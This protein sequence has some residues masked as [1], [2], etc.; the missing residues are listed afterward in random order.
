MEAGRYAG[1]I[2][3]RVQRSTEFLL[4]NDSYSNKRHWAPPKGKVIGNEDQV[5]CAIRETVDITGL[6]AKS[7]QIADSNFRI[8]IKYLSGTTPKHVA[9]FVASIAS[10]ER[11]VPSGLAGLNMAW[12][13]LQQAIEKCMYKNM[14]DALRQANAYIEELKTKIPPPLSTN[15][16]SGFG[17]VH[18]EKGNVNGGVPSENGRNRGDRGDRRKGGGRGSHKGGEEGGAYSDE[19]AGGRMR[20]GEGPGRPGTGHSQQVPSAR[21]GGSRS[22]SIGED[23]TIARVGGSVFDKANGNEK[24]LVFAPNGSKVHWR[25]GGVIPGSTMPAST[26]LTSKEKKEETPAVPTS[27][28][29]NPLYKTRLCERFETE[30]NCPYGARCSFAHGTSELRDRSTYIGD[31]KEQKNEQADNPLYKTRYCERFLKE[32][33]CQYGPRCNFAHSPEELRVRPAND[34]AEQAKQD[35]ADAAAAQNAHPPPVKVTKANRDDLIT[36]KDLMS[37]K[38]KVGR[39]NTRVVE[40]PIGELQPD[41]ANS[42][43]GASPLSVPAILAAPL[44]ATGSVSSPS[45]PSATVVK[46]NKIEESLVGDLTKYFGSEA[47]RTIAEETKEITRIEFKHDL[48]KQQ[49]FNVLIPSLF[50]EDYTNGKLQERKAFLQQYIRTSSDQTAFLKAWDKAMNRNA[51]LMKK[52]TVVFKCLYDVDLIEEDIFMAW[53]QGAGVSEAVKKKCQ[54]L[55]EWFKTAEEEED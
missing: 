33:F 32:S 6:S 46:L 37:D 20:R 12:L 8:E 24:N 27:V 26:L 25:T 16:R 49:L 50:D 28:T 45:T 40:V 22:L 18:N 14:Q 52:A 3:Y 31:Q 38:D 7:I 51:N 42:S 53:S 2:L 44:S 13:P 34:E 5:K 21:A 29:E 30:G 41:R 19:N 1:I 55:I 39:K 23:G 47:K 17:N 35:A 11:I 9:Y 48:T 10:R 54:P 15:N 43:G 4:L 36:L